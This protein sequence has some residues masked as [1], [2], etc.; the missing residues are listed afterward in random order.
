MVRQL[1]QRAVDNRR[2]S[3]GSVVD[4]VVVASIHQELERC[5]KLSAEFGATDAELTSYVGGA[6]YDVGGWGSAWF[7]GV[8]GVCVERVAESVFRR[9]SHAH[10]ADISELRTPCGETGAENSCAPNPY[11][12][13]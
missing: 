13:W 3:P 7:A 9:P 1:A 4:R 5:L 2:G 12:L 8:D 6:E 11:H 10:T